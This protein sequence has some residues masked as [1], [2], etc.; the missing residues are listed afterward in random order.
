MADQTASIDVRF[1]AAIFSA[2]IVALNDRHIAFSITVGNGS[3]I[4]VAHKTT[5]IVRTCNRRFGIALGNRAAIIVANQTTGVLASRHTACNA[6]SITVDDTD[7]TRFDGTTIIVA[8]QAAS[9][10]LA[11]NIKSKGLFSAGNNSNTTVFD[12]AVII[13]PNQAAGIVTL[14]CHYG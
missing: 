9:I 12:G 10:A 5:N 11:Q 4:I 8:N 2:H 3:S 13:I 1:I 7:A 14:T 6:I